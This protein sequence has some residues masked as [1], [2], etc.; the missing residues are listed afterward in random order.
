MLIDIDQE[1]AAKLLRWYGIAAGVDAADRD[2]LRMEFNDYCCEAMEDLPEEFEEFEDALCDTG[3]VVLEKQ[4]EVPDSFESDHLKRRDFSLVQVEAD[5]EIAS[6]NGFRWE[7]GVKHANH[8]V[9]SDMIPL[10]LVK[11]VASG[12]LS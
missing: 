10:D 4:F 11:K 6:L 1:E 5:H 2:F 12:E 9:E 3:Y 7:F 8:S